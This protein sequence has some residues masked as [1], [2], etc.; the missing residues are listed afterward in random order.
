MK[1]TKLQYR[2]DDLLRKHALH[3]SHHKRQDR[4]KIETR[5]T[6]YPIQ[7]AQMDGCIDDGL[8][9]TLCVMLC[10]DTVC[11]IFGVSDVV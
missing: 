5:Q 11:V 10:G 2:M 3:T 8:C 1:L 4:D 6:D 9:L 7:R